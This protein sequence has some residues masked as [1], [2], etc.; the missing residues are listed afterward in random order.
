MAP[1]ITLR[2]CC[3]Q[4]KLMLPSASFRESSFELS[5][6]SECNVDAELKDDTLGESEGES[7]D[8]ALL[9]EREDD[10]DVDEASFFFLSPLD[11]RVLAFCCCCCF[12]CLFFCFLLRPIFQ[13]VKKKKKK[14]KKLFFR[15]SISLDFCKCPSFK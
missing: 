6:E 10:V 4:V 11:V 8:D 3:P 7:D 15:F 1:R 12:F 14:K 5:D 13:I 2:P 9:D